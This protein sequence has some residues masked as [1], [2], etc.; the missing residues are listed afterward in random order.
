MA[1]AVHENLLRLIANRGEMS[2]QEFVG[3]VTRVRGDY[4]DFYGAAAMLHSGYICT[5]STADS[6][7]ENIRGILGA[8]TQSTAVCLCQLAL[9]SG[10][11]FTFNECPRDSWHDFP[12]KIFITGEG[13]LKLEELDEKAETKTKRRFD[14]FFAVFIAILAAVLGGL[15]TSYFTPHQ[16][17]YPTTQT[18]PQ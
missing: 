4:T 14:Y 16:Q 15:A 6:R 5:D 8:D 9:P 17:S 3:K 11:S 10:G 18:T 2:A 13:L 1:A 12:L 7:G